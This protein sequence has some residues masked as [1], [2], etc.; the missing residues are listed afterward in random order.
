MDVVTI[1]AQPRKTGKGA[2]RAVR[3]SGNVPCVV[4]G[5]GREPLAFQ[6]AEPQIKKIVFSPEKKRI[7]ISIDG[8]SIDCILKDYELHPLTE[9]PFH[10]DFQE[11][12]KGEKIHV[13]VP[14][15]YIGTPVGQVEDGGDTSVL[16]HEIEV[17]CLPQHIPTHIELEISHLRIGESL[18]VSDLDVPNVEF[19]LAA[20]TPLV[21]VLAPRLQAAE[22]EEVEAEQAGEEEKEEEE[23]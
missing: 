21:N 18:R 9:R 12:R 17:T 16:V 15:R 22:A 4:Y 6:V 13:S 20:E 8:K 11:L 1:E 2:A 14:I 19:R 7:R 23:S 3:R 5:H 10:V